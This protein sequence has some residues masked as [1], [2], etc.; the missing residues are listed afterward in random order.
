[1]AVASLIMGI[2][3]FVLGCCVYPAYI[4]GALAIILALLSRGGERT[5]SGMARAGMILGILAIIL[6]TLLL[7]FSFLAVLKEYGS[8]ENYMRA[9]YDM[10]EQIYPGYSDMYNTF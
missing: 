9:V 5:C 10:M 2:L 8:F 1:M 4:F 7:V 3:A 6:I